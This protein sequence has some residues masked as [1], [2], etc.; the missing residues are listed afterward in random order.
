M[1]D[2]RRSWSNAFDPRNSF[3]TSMHV[4]AGRQAGTVSRV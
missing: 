2:D 1:I 4:Q 3:G